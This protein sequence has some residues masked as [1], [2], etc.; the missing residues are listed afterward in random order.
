[1]LAVG[2]AALF[3]PRPT[4]APAVV[5]QQPTPRPSPSPAVVVPIAVHVGGEVA[6]P[7]LYRLPPGSRIDDALRAAGGVTPDGDVERVNLAARLA[8]GQQVVVPRKAAK[9]VAGPVTP[10]KVNVNTA[11]VAELDVLPGIGPATA[12]RIVACCPQS[13]RR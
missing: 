2:L 4:P 3:L 12:Q 7:G 6:G 9:A 10:A 11:T 1:M 13:P 8:D 5:V